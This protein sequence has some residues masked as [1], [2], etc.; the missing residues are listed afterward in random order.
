MLLPVNTKCECGHQNAVGTV[1]CE[2]CGKPLE[3]ELLESNEP[4]E[5]RYDGVARR[6]QKANPDYLDKIW[7]FFSSVKIAIYLIIITFVGAMLGTIF[8]QASTFISSTFDP[9]VYYAEQYGLPGK[10]YYFL[11]L[12]RTYTSWWFITLLVMIATSLV[13]CSIDRVLPLYRALSK[14]QIRKHHAFLKRQKATYSTTLA[15]DEAEWTKQYGQALR[16]KG[17]KVFV[18]ESG[19]A[20]LAEKNRFSR[21]GPY[22]N[23]I[24]LILF[25]LAVLARSIPG[26]N[27]DQYVSIADGDTVPI[28]GT[29]YYVKSEGFKI[30]LYE[31]EELPEELKD[32][33]RIK[34]FKTEVVLYECSA[35]CNDDFEQPTLTEVHQH[36]ILVNDPLRYKEL[37]LHQFDFNLTPRINA[38][39][40]MVVNVQT[41]ESYGPFHLKMVEPELHYEVGP[42]TLELIDKYMDFAINSEGE[43]ITLSS[44]PNAPAFIFNIKGPGLAEAGEVFMYFPLEKDKVRF[45]QDTINREL[46]NKVAIKVEGM[47]NVD[48]SAATTHLNVRI[49]KAI[50]YLW[51]GAVISMIGLVMGTYWQHRRIWLRIDDQQLTLGAHTNKNWYGL[52][53]DIAYALKHCGIELDP[54]SLDNGGHKG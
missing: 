52:R 40:P 37:K 30:E 42:Y 53:A 10:I 3:K 49:D 29:N 54:K 44:S 16:K 50:K 8:P 51:I 12:H 34:S 20:L 32:S 2:S 4:L 13:I 23:H 19:T 14:Q 22:I 28:V 39:S 33:G 48:F 26:W 5:M 18:D 47:E 35:N 31:N 45:S 9:S 24:G 17:Y 7:N 46:A 1:L 36:T 6:S 11:G 21:W 43:P 15:E 41:G 27:V 38:V 25:L